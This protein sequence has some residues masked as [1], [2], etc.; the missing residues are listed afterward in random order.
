[1]LGIERQLPFNST[2]AVT[3]T[4]SHG[5]H[6]LRSRDINAPLPGTFNPLTATWTL[7]NSSGGPDRVFRFGQP[8]D[9]PVV[10]DWNGSGQDTVG[11]FDAL[12]ATW[13]LRASNSAGPAD[14]S[15]QFGQPGT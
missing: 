10:G 15:F 3:L 1:M 6:L 2:L 11:V 7:H 12:T 4:D 8:G 5:E 14:V 13:S 9:L